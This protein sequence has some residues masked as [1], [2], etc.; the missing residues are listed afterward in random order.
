M[1][2]FSPKWVRRIKDITPALLFLLVTTIFIAFSGGADSLQNWQLIIRAILRFLRLTI[3]LCL[4]L[5]ALLPIYSLIV[6]KKRNVL[7]RIE[8]REDL[9]V[10][11]LKHW[12]FRPLQGAGIGLLFGTKLLSVLQLIAGA[13][14]KSS[15]L[16]PEG[17]FQVDRLIMTTVITILV[18]LFLSTLWALDDMGIRYFNRRDQEIKMIGKYVGTLMPVIF[19][20]YGVLGLFANFPRVQ[21]LVYLFKIL[22]VLYPPLAVFAVVHTYFIKNRGAFLSKSIQIKKGG[23]YSIE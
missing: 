1:V 12:V 19:G 15:L 4:P 9:N 14:V 5:Y 8:Q 7:L 6:D 21:A 13:T 11:P 3:S 22:V 17:Q 20:L 10:H 18:S 23:I 2:H 16:I